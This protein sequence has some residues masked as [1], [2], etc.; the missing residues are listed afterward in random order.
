MCAI[1]MCAVAA[2]PAVHADEHDSELEI[3]AVLERPARG[4]PTNF[5]PSFAFE[6]TPIEHW[7]EVETGLSRIQLEGAAEWEADLTF[8]KP[9][10][11]SPSRELLVGFGPAWT[12]T[13]APGE[14]VNA[15]G[16]EFS[17]DFQFYTHGRWG[18]F[19]EPSYSVGFGH[20]TEKTVAITFG[21]LIGM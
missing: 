2:S 12:H 1:F 10:E 14:P 4:G 7:L 11:L 21:L 17:V 13:H 20:G 9:F 18:W 19:I 15:W 16:G 3:G 6:F 5:G 8:K